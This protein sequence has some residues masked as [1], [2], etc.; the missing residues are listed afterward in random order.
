[1]GDITIPKET[2]TPTASAFAEKLQKTREN[3]KEALTKAIQYMKTAYDKHKNKRIYERDPHVVGCRKSQYGTSQ[4]QTH[5]QTSWAFCHIGS[6]GKFP[7]DMHL[8]GSQPTAGATHLRGVGCSSSL[9]TTIPLSIDVLNL[10]PLPPPTTIK[11]GPPN[12][13]VDP[14]S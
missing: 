3:T 12:D 11:S 2:H 5:R 1:M 8:K 10:Y 4:Y 14:P 9:R 6:L 13:S 7:P